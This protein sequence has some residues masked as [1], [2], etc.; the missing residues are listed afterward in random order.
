[1]TEARQRFLERRCM[2]RTFEALFS[3]EVKKRRDKDRGLIDHQTGEAAWVKIEA[4]MMMGK[5]NELR[6][7]RKKS[8]IDMERY[9]RMEQLC[10][11]H[12]D[13]SS[14]LCLYSMELVLDEE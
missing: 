14:K 8:P 2:T 9:R 4:E 1:M 13:Y 3:N 11:G 12:S 10:I 7:V 6:R 5:I